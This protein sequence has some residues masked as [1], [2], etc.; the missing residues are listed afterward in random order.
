MGKK[1]STMTDFGNKSYKE[2][3]LRAPEERTTR[4]DLADMK[5]NLQ[6]KS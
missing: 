5:P 4:G 1:K 2:A 3:G 6:E